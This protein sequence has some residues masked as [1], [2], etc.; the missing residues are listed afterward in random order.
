MHY[1]F[2]SW[3]GGRQIEIFYLNK[4]LWLRKKKISEERMDSFIN[5][6]G[7]TG[8]LSGEN[9]KPRPMLYI[10]INS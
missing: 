9:M 7:T 2:T 3:G 6:A 4:Y 8:N 1:R 5:D 10:K